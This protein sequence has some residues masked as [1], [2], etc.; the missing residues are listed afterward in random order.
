MLALPVAVEPS[1][2]SSAAI[3][4]AFGIN[5]RRQGLDSD[6]CFPST[7]GHLL[8]P[9]YFDPSLRLIVDGLS[10]LFLA[11]LPPLESGLCICDVSPFLEAGPLPLP[12]HLS[13]FPTLSSIVI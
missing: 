4:S 10:S 7:S 12:T 11:S 9:L 13:D 5:P 2:A 8:I 6:I 3:T 1:A